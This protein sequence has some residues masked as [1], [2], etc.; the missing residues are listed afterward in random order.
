RVGR[1][2]LSRDQSLDHRRRPVAGLRPGRGTP[3]GYLRGLGLH[4]TNLRTG[5]RDGG[6]RDDL[7]DRVRLGLRP[8][9]AVLVR[10]A[11]GGGA[12]VL[13]VVCFGAWSWKGRT[14]PF[15]VNP[16]LGHWRAP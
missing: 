13:G 7:R 4:R 5:R 12:L 2:D 14:W 1:G 6:H 3:A 10:A 9:A 11:R 16:P 15:A 8:P